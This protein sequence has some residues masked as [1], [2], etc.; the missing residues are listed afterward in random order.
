MDKKSLYLCL[1]LFVS[2]I[3]LGY[4][5]CF[6]V[7][8]FMDDEIVKED[9]DIEENNDDLLDNNNENSDEPLV[10][11]EKPA[12]EIYEKLVHYSAEYVDLASYIVDF[13][14]DEDKNGKLLNLVV[15]GIK[16]DGKDYTFS[17]KNHPKNCGDINNYE[18]YNYNQFYINDKLIYAQ[19]NQGCYLEGI[20]YITIIDNSYIVLIYTRQGNDYMKIYDKDINLVDT[21]E[22]VN[23]EI[24]KDEIIYSEYSDND[25]CYLNYFKYDIVNGNIINEFKKNVKNTECNEMTG[26]GCNC[27]NGENDGIKFD[28]RNENETYVF[29]KLTLNFNGIKTGSINNRDSYRYTLDILLDDKKIE[30]NLFTNKDNRVIWSKDYA[31]SFKF[32]DVGDYYILVSFIAK[33][34]DGNYVLVMDKEGNIVRTFEDVSIVI[35]KKNLELKVT[36]CESDSITSSC[37]SKVYSL[38]GFN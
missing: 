7:D 10:E 2:S 20:Q 12:T 25:G 33:Q 23:I 16:L 11:E 36:D 15:D 26:A 8:S 28:L 22:Y 30:T 35:D 19:N 1:I 31:A 3:L 34:N 21:V 32:V 29:D 14:I 37:S 5:S 27:D 38:N 9:N 24:K 17:F 13:D 6:V 18:E 4:I